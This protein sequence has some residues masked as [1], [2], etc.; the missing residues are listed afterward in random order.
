MKT[1]ELL[2][3]LL[4][5]DICGGTVNEEALEP[6]SGEMLKAV[7]DLSR[8]HDLAHIAGQALSNLGMLGTDDISENFRATSMQ[9]VYRYVQM[10]HAFGQLCCAFE[11]A[12][13]PFLPLKGAV[14]RNYYPD[15]WMRTSCDIDILVREE[16]LE[17]AIKVLVTE[18]GYRNEGRGYHD[19]S[20]FS[21]G[22]VHVELHFTLVEESRFSNAQ[23]IAEEVWKYTSPV[24]G[25]RVQMQMHDEM[26]YFYHILHMANH[27]YCG[28]CGIRPFLDLWI[29][30]HKV[31]YD[32]Q[33][34]EALLKTG[35][36]LTFAHVAQAL[37]EAWFSDKP[38][39]ALTKEL[40]KFILGGG[41]YGSVENKAA[42]Q[43]AKEGGRLRAILSKI[44]LPY[45][46]LK[47]HYPI[48][49][50]HKWMFPIFQVFRWFRLFSKDRWKRSV[51][52]MQTNITIT[53]EEYTSAA[54]LMKQLGL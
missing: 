50:T 8:K 32:A 10:N 35:G 52:E 36:L 46:V 5:V 11:S 3:L 39:T 27:L 16:E 44:F 22:N 47:G 24:E 13:I 41:V 49:Q 54:K 31:A 28:G 17:R 14:I 38:H 20:L 42:V 40:E 29:L 33:K 15:P 37:S 1:E 25:S 34:R 30:N 53:K 6:L 23:K 9:A 45:G 51:C 2:F 4:R 12:R 26:F 43:Q 21:P 7:Y 19:V 48:L 18:L